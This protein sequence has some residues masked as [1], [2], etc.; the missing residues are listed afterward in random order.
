[1]TGAFTITV[2]SDDFNRD[3]AA[4]LTAIPIL[5]DRIADQLA[6][7][8]AQEGGSAA[9]RLG[10]PWEISGT[11]PS[12]RHVEAPEWWAHFIA[13]G[14]SGHGPVSAPQLV[15]DVG[16]GTVFAGFVSGIGATHFDEAA[17]SDTR[18]DLDAIFTKL[19]AELT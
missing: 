7:D 16:S 3:M 5:I 14:T 1:M 2:D 11:G 6:E 4:M 17:M 10:A 8:L 13:G 12:E 19:V 18:M 15:F 9:S